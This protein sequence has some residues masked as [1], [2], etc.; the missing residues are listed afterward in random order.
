MQEDI[1]IAYGIATLN[2]HRETIFKSLDISHKTGLLETKKD[3]S[4][5]ISEPF[6]EKP[7]IRDSNLRWLV[8]VLGTLSGFGSFFCYDNP[9][10]LQQYIQSTFDI[11]DAT[12]NLLYSVAILPNIIVP[13][14]GGALIDSI[15]VRATMLITSFLVLLGQITVTL[16]AATLSFHV[17]ILG[18]L[19]FGFGYAT[20]EN[21]LLIM[22]SKWFLRKN[23]SFAWGFARCGLRISSALNSI[24]SPKFYAYKNELYFPFLM[25]ACLTLLSFLC[26]FGVIYLDAKADQETPYSAQANLFEKIMLKE[27]KS[28]PKLFF[29]LMVICILGYMSFL[30]FTNNV[31]NLLTTRFGFVTD[32]AGELISFIYLVAGFLSPLMGSIIDMVGKRVI[33]IFVAVFLALLSQFFFVV[34]PDATTNAPNYHVIFGFIGLGLFYSMFSTTIFPSIPLI[35]KPQNIGTALGI[36]TCLAALAQ[37]GYT[38][39]IGWVHDTTIT[40]HFGYFWTQIIHCFVFLTICVFVFF[41]Y[42]EDIRNN[43]GI[44]NK[45]RKVLESEQ[46]NLP[47]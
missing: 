44:L 24:L 21:S 10:P 38:E 11:K 33:F 8:L 9:Q 26:V 23:M 30:G 40:V 32:V 14:F 16:G 27:F 17:M 5:V 7:S 22:L 36:M 41:A 12:S 19:V 15:G 34:L 3:R 2:H 47:S 6:P 39:L 28:L 18:R 45:G 37:A 29:F 4:P 31:N 43:N 20:L 13:L 42:F 46:Q 35:I 25:G 1:D